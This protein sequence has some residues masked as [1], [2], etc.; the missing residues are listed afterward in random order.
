[1]APIPDYAQITSAWQ[2]SIGVA[3]QIGEQM[4]FEADYVNT[5]SRHEKSIQDNVNITFDP[6]TGEPFPYSNVARRAF[7]LYGV[8]GMI[9]HTG[10]SDYHGLQTSFTKRMAN[11]WQASVTYTLSGLWDRD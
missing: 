4:A 11:R 5:R 10:E 2:T 9:P 6:A 1:M 7:P 8:V 3:H